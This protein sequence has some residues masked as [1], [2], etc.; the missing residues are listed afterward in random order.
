MRF[1]TRLIGRGQLPPTFADT[2]SGV[3]AEEPEALEEQQ[4]FVSTPAGGRL[5]R[6]APNSP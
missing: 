2:L 5:A 4:A 3:G 1:P 6:T